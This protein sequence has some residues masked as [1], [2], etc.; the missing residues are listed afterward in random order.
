MRAGADPDT[1]AAP[2]EA[3]E[4]A[5]RDVQRLGS[6]P[7]GNLT[8]Q[9]G[10][11]QSPPRRFLAAHREGLHERTTFSRSSYPTTLY[12]ATA[13]HRPALDPTRLTPYSS[14][15]PTRPISG[16]DRKSVV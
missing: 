5:D 6:L 12:V 7:I 13:A 4:V 2:L 10:L 3:L 9:G 8:G 15:R 11:E 14:P 16:G 1:G